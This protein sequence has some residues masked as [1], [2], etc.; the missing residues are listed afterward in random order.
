VAIY[1]L[2]ESIRQ[3]G[4]NEP[5]VVCP[6]TEGG[7]ELLCGNRRKRGCE[8]AGFT[9]MP[10]IIKNLDDASAVLVMVDSNLDHRKILLSERAA[11]YSMMMDALNHNGVKGDCHSYEIMVERTGVKKSQLFR[12]IRLTELIAPLADMVDASKLSFNPAVELS[13]LTIT[14]QTAVAEAMAAHMVK[15]SLSQAQRLK[16]A[17]Q[18]R[19][20]TLPM[21]ESVLSEPKKA[22]KANLPR[23]TR[24]SDYFPPGTSSKQ[25][26]AVIVGLLK[27]WKAGASA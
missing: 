1:R 19:R 12:I 21:I 15:P 14:E 18:D 25:M 23:Y 4:V 22:P 9:A 5:G 10:V 3:S 6:R 20:L 26:E 16:K 2:A 7:Y 17:S 13:Y 24:F 11:A 27:H 8:I